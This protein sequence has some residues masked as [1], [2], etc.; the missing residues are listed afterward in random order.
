MGDFAPPLPP[1]KSQYIAPG[2]CNIRFAPRGQPAN[3]CLSY[4]GSYAKNYM[5]FGSQLSGLWRLLSI[6]SCAMKIGGMFAPLVTP[7]EA[8]RICSKTR[9]SVANPPECSNDGDY[10]LR[11][12]AKT[13]DVTKTYFAQYSAAT[14]AWQWVLSVVPGRLYGGAPLVSPR[15]ISRYYF[16]GGC[17]RTSRKPHRGA[18]TRGCRTAIIALLGGAGGAKLSS[19]REIWI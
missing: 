7:E 6:K 2:L 17:G 9:T 12:R 3:A 19:I 10:L 1:P 13:V 16:M 5:G 14:L 11:Y 18:T 8:G 4:L 15:R